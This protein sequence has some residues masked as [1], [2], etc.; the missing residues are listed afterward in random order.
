MS[1]GAVSVGRRDQP[2]R[3]TAAFSRD[4]FIARIPAILGEIQAALFNQ[5]LAFR[6]QYTTSDIQTFREF[7]AYFT[8]KS[9][10]KPEIHGGFVRAKWCG[11]AACEDRMAELA[12]TI[13]CLPFDQNGSEG[14]CVICGSP[15]TT[16]A[17]MAKA[18]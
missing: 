2:V 14:K 13:R 10:D 7:E 18:Y 5:A 11:S 12:V 1:A 6:D 16:T 4:E 9:Q 15:A 3:Q 17:I 8:P